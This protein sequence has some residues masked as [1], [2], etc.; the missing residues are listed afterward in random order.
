MDEL[1]KKLIG[2]NA[3]KW[4]RLGMMAVVL[5]VTPGGLGILS[6][7]FADQSQ[8]VQ[9]LASIEATRSADSAEILELKEKN[10]LSNQKIL[11][12]E[13][14]AKAIKANQIRMESHF[15]EYRTEQRQ[16]QMEMRQWM[17]TK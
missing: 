3:G 15:D 6:S 11:V 2:E 4:E 10:L 14:E 5:L 16:F 13:T 12:I 8:T 7:A 17:M 1:L 9:R